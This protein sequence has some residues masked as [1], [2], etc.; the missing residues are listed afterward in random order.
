MSDMAIFRQQPFSDR[1]NSAALIDL[2]SH[3]AY[4]TSTL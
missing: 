3:P 2:P 4:H 1:A